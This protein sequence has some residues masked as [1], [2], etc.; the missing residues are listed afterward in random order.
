MDMQ[1]LDAAFKLYLQV[2]YASHFSKWL[3]ECL[4][5]GYLTEVTG[6]NG[7]LEYHINRKLV[8]EDAGKVMDKVLTNR[9]GYEQ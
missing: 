8:R 5:E 9:N 3:E 6:E 2:T 1:K 4:R 7:E